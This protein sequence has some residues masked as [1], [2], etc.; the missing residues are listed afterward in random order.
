M[1]SI[2]TSDL[3]EGMKF[4]KAVFMDGENVFVPAGVPIRQKD[5]ERLVRWDIETVRTDGTLVIDS[6]RSQDTA[7]D[8]PHQAQH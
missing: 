4:D 5:I 1:K 7:L 8:L 6:P 2:K 3:K